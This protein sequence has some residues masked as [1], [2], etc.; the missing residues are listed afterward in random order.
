MP[1]LAR[2]G[3]NGLDIGLALGVL[4]SV[5]LGAWRGL[6]YEVV[7]VVG[8]VLAFVVAQ[9]YA[10]TT[11]QWLGFAATSPWL[12]H[13]FGFAA[14]FIG[15]AFVGGIAAVVAQKLV[16]AVGLRPIDRVLGAGFG[17][18]RAAILLLALAFVAGLTVFKS[19]ELWQGSLIAQA[20]SRAV[21][22]LAPLLPAN[23]AQWL[24]RK[25]L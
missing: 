10:A 21:E 4:G 24:Q 19:S 3:L 17:L 8:W 23:A 7:A 14:V 12:N 18:L 16:Q 25:Q 2:L 15:M 13:A 1:E 5:L 9:V 22:A 6:V 11:G 20:S